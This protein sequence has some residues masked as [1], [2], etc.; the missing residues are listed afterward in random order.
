V[1]GP[2][3]TAGWLERIRKDHPDVIFYPEVGMDPVTCALAALRLAPLQAA[4]WGHPVT[5]GLA[6]IDLFFSG[7]LLESPKADAHYRERLI[8]L[9][10]TGACTQAR[11]VSAAVW[12]GDAPGALRFALPHQ[13]IKMDPEDDVLLTRIAKAVGN[14]EFWLASPGKLGWATERLRARLAR[15]FRAEG[16]D[17][18]RYLRVTPWLPRERFLGYLD[19]MD[20]YLDSPAFSG[21]TTA[22]Q[23]LQ[24]GLPMVTL[25]GTFMRQR[26]AAGLLRQIEVPDG[27]ARSKDD[28]VT[29]ASRFAEESRITERRRATREAIRQASRRADDN[30]SA[31]SAL[32]DVMCQSLAARTR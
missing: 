28:Y 17:P 12:D 20:V 16:L 15:V 19:A 22:W 7:A 26:L 27:I 29:L 25:E 9:P 8:R 11:P 24:R 6:S 23:A 31:V 14:C 2:K 21:Y 32:Q 18:E 1:Q 4:S 3:S 13:P 5:T 10:G 30:R